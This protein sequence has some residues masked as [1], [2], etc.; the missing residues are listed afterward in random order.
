MDYG[1]EVIYCRCGWSGLDSKHDIDF[2]S[3]VKVERGGDHCICSQNE[4]ELLK[5]I[6]SLR[7]RLS[8][9]S[10]LL[11]IYEGQLAARAQTAGG[12]ASERRMNRRRH[13]QRP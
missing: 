8:Q 10:A 2:L 3:H 13:A 1:Q 12:A 9:Q 6:R 4:W 7:E 5:E 11:N